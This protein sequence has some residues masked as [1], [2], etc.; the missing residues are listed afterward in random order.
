M[1]VLI[2]WYNFCGAWGCIDDTGM[3]VLVLLC[4]ECQKDVRLAGL[5]DF[6]GCA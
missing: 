2:S 3:S 4:I 1:Q 5:G 6:A